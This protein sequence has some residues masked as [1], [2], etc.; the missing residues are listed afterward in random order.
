MQTE[1]TGYTA[2]T[3]CNLNFNC[4]YDSAVDAGGNPAEVSPASSRCTCNTRGG[5][6][7]PSLSCP[8]HITLVD[9]VD[10]NDNTCYSNTTTAS[11]D[12]TVAVG[13]PKKASQMQSLH[14]AIKTEI[15]R[16]RINTSYDDIVATAGETI[17]FS[18]S[19]ARIKANLYRLTGFTL[20]VN[21][22]DL[23]LASDIQTAYTKLNTA[24]DGCVCVER[25]TCNARTSCVA[26]TSAIDDIGLATDCYT[27]CNCDCHEVSS[28]CTCDSH[29]PPECTC[30]SYCSC[31]TYDWDHHTWVQNMSACGCDSDCPARCTCDCD[32]V[33]TSCVCNTRCTCDTRESVECKCNIRENCGSF[34]AF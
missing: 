27:R 1:N 17:N 20:N 9:Q 21:A 15:A 31:N 3:D 2:G 29:N 7:K 32:A 19:M 25:C 30:N 23:M 11:A 24:Q 26:R 8:F 16:R 22:G 34:K 14:T 4:V 5:E 13:T 28:N 18:D 33:S 10:Y 12:S 6:W